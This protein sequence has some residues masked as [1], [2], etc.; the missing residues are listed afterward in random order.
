MEIP[1]LESYSD[2]S[3]SNK[4]LVTNGSKKIKSQYYKKPL[5]SVITIVLN[6]EQTIEK[7]IKS[8]IN[9]SYE[10]YEFIIIECLY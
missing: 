6:A 7:T 2:Y 4:L 3:P 1:H 9:Q 10:N 8:V 5:I